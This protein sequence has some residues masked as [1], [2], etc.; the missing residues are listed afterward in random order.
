MPNLSASYQHSQQ[1]ICV[2]LA[3]L[4]LVC[5]NLAY[6]VLAC[7]V[8]ACQSYHEALQERP[9]GCGVALGGV[10]CKRGYGCDHGVEDT[11]GIPPCVGVRGV[12]GSCKGAY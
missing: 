1:T 10:A 12:H 9:Y 5:P 8:L 11:H 7:L 3:Y 4:A 2:G 6:L